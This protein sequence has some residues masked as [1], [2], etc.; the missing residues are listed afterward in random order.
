MKIEITKLKI[1]D[2]DVSWGEKPLVDCYLLINPDKSKLNDLK[3]MIEGRFDYNFDDNI[4]EEDFAK[5]ESFLSNIWDNVYDFINDNF[6][7]VDVDTSY[8]IEW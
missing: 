3:E 6:I 8:E 7:V 1:I 2:M 4:S 5:A